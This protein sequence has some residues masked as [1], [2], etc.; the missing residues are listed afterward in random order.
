MGIRK[1]EGEMAAEMAGDG[2][3]VSEEGI[4]EDNEGLSSY[5]PFENKL[6]CDICCLF[7]YCM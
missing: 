4:T 3:K 2:V 5:S 7:I 1:G 6:L